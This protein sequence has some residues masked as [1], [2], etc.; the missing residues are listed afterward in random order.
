MTDD[1]LPDGP[2]ALEF[3]SGV[4]VFTGEPFV[5]IRLDGRLI[6]QVDPETARRIGLDALAVAEAAESDA[7]IVRLL[8]ETVGLDEQ[9]A[10]S[11]LV[12]MRDARSTGPPDEQGEPHQ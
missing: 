3:L 9:A 2:G 1:L 4:S 8:T 6:G 7:L 10:L 5:H 11:F 12:A